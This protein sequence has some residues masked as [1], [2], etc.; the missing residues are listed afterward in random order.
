[1][2]SKRLTDLSWS[3]LGWRLQFADEPAHISG[4]RWIRRYRDFF[5][6]IAAGAIERSK[7]K[8]SRSWQDARKRHARLAFWAAKSLNGKQRYCGWKIDHGSPPRI[9][10]ERKSL[11]HR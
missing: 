7:F 9:G 4:F 6:M 10:H 8:S 5:D 2:G 1:M 11:G 3:V